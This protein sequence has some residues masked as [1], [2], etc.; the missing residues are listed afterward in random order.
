MGILNVG[1]QTKHEDYE[2]STEHLKSIADQHY[3]SI[4][5]ILR[6]EVGDDIYDQLLYG[7]SAP[8]DEGQHQLMK[9]RDFDIILNTCKQRQEFKTF[10]DTQVNKLNESMNY[11]EDMSF[12]N[13]TEQEIQEREESLLNDNSM[14]SHRDSFEQSKIED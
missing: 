1:V 11:Q 3:L 12:Q 7:N 4:K 10:I 2:L 14:F 8:R 9:E 13:L 6:E 5:Q